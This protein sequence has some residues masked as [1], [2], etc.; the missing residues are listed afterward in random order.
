MMSISA[1]AFAADVMMTPGSDAAIDLGSSAP[2]SELVK[3]LRLS[4]K[5]AQDQIAANQDSLSGETDADLMDIYNQEIKTQQ[6]RIV[7]LTAQL[8][9]AVEAQKKQDQDAFALEKLIADGKSA[10][11]QIDAMAARSRTMS[12]KLAAAEQVI[13]YQNARALSIAEQSKKQSDALKVAISDNASAKAKM[14]RAKA[15]EALLKETRAQSANV[16]LEISA[17]ANSVN[18]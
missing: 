17:L 10:A 8:S 13:R 11:A 7:Q 16:A 6:D 1:A 5:E 14:M 12:E 18:E 3:S 4:I 9:D 2:E 15:D